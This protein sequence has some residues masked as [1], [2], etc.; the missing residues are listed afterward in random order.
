MVKMHHDEKTSSIL[1]DAIPD[2]KEC[3]E[4]LRMS[5]STVFDMLALRGENLSHNLPD[6]LPID[7][8]IQ[9]FSTLAE[10]T[11]NGKLVSFISLLKF[12]NKH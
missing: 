12:P 7:A 6:V 11:F 9:Q 1:K 2:K 10:S 8:K 3:N 4:R 5:E